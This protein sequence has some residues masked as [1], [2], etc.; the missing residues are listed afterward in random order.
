MNSLELG[1]EDIILTKDNVINSESGNPFVV[2]DLIDRGAFRDINSVDITDRYPALNLSKLI[3][4][5]FGK[6]GIGVIVED[7]TSY[8]NQLYLMFSESNEVNKTEKWKQDHALD[9]YGVGVIFNDTGYNTEFSIEEP[10]AFQ[11]IVDISE[12]FINPTYTT[13]EDGVYNIKLGFNLKLRHT[14]NAVVSN[15]VLEMQILKNGSVFKTKILPVD[16]SISNI[17]NIVD[18][19]TTGPIRLGVN[20]T[21]STN[22]KFTG[23]IQHNA[24]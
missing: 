20:D 18:T 19:I 17:K 8:Y 23:D 6:Y 3:E 24:M 22:L 21:I 7:N 10:L 12:S 15:S 9:T 16:F 5:S 13:K 1:S 11:P 4:K 2:F 14:R